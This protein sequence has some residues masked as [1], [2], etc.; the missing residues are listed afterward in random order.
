MSKQH[1]Y[2]STL[3]WTGNKGEGTSNYRAYD[4]SYEISIASK[5]LIQG[6][7]DPAFSGDNNKHNPEELL[8]ASISSCHMLWF[9]HFCA[10]AGVI[11]V[12][13][14]DQASATMIEESNGSGYFTRATLKPQVVVTNNAMLAQLNALHQKANQYCFIANSVKFPVYHEATG[15][16]I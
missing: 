11:V 16:L 4:R 3:T 2:V 10:Q 7:S 5:A 12:S 6:S 8:L 14:T 1:I 13:Y 15:V 9:L